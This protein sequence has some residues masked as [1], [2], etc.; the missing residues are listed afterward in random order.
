LNRSQA[1][2][3]MTDRVT[4]RSPDAELVKQFLGNLSSSG[5]KGEIGLHVADRLVNAT[6]NSVY[7][8]MPAAV[9][10][11]RVADDL[12]LI[13]SL[14]SQGV[15][16]IPLAAR[17][18]GTG[19]NGQALSAGVVV[20]TSRHLNR[21]LKFD[22]ERLRVVVE[23]GVVLGQLNA[24]LGTHGLFFPPTV[25]T[26]NRATLGGMIATDASGKGSRLY[27]KTSDYIE[28]M[29]VVLA[30]GSNF[31]VVPTPVSQIEDL[32][33]QES[34]AARGQL[35]VLRTATTF[36][37]EIDD[38]F[39]DMNR[40]LTGYN[41]KM[42]LDPQKGLMLHR[43]LAGSE[44][45]L[46]ITKFVELRVCRKPRQRVLLV[47]R[48][49]SFDGAL[50]DVG[51]L[52]GADPAAI[53]TIDDK[54]LALAQQDT[55]WA[56]LEG[57]LGHKVARDVK[58]INFV[59]LA[60]DDPADIDAR[61][62]TLQE[63]M[64][65]SGSEA[66][67]DYTLVRDAKLIDS[68]WGLREKSVGLL[69]KLPGKRQGAAFVE[70]TA[71]PP[72]RLPEY[73][74]EFR[75]ILDRHGLVYGMF[76]HADVGCLHVRPAL[77]MTNR[78]DAALLRPISDEV[79]ALAKRYGGLLWGEHGRG[80]RGEYSPFFFGPVLYAELCKIKAAFDPQNIF[81]PGKLAS[82]PG[83]PAVI[84]IDEPPLRGE[85]DRQIAA[86]VRTGYAAALSCNGNGVCFSWDAQDPMCPSYKATRDRSQ[87]PKGRATLLREWMRRK[88]LVA[89]SFSS[90]SLYEVEEAVHDSL[91]SCL[92]CKA[93]ANQCPI[94]VDIPAMKARFLNDYYR[95]RR[96]PLR[97]HL[98][99]EMERL[100]PL[101]R[102]WPRAAN[103]LMRSRAIRALISAVGLVD[104]PAIDP[105]GLKKSAFDL[106]ALALLSIKEKHRSVILVPDS[107]TDV[108][109]GVVPAA[110]HSLLT[111]LGFR[112]HVAPLYP[113][114][115][116]LHVLGFL[117][118]FR[119]VAEMARKRHK[120]ML[121]TGVPVLGIEPVATLMDRIE[122][123]EALPCRG[124]AV[125][126]TIDEF[127]AQEI[128]E[129]RISLPDSRENSI[130]H[131]FLHCTERTAMPAVETRWR[132][133]FKAFGLQLFIE[134]T[135][136][137][138]MAGL[139][140]H[141][142]EHAEMSK[143]LFAMSWAEP[144]QKL[145][146][147]QLL[148]TGFSCRSQAKRL[149]GRQLRHPVQALLEALGD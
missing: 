68:L 45:T 8:V 62:V 28:S 144:I 128:D 1:R 11:P 67:L 138:G 117:E 132:N 21:I 5:Y 40:G 78:H 25:S 31:R 137:C 66:R 111:K 94:Q 131:L 2:T 52:L 116:P 121:D 9:L 44:G 107:F 120:Q 89:T 85:F 92:S 34:L 58:A 139:F 65:Q 136:C 26:A 80:F 109:D 69:G 99:G 53:E 64:E 143:N 127:L 112:V 47:I 122:Y 10:Y 105:S 61:V 55:M 60:S 91:S 63:L 36:R 75:A 114:G 82:L 19:T 48:Y 103:A 140:G 23:P 4:S 123:Q 6:D 97:H 135:G 51:P 104:L 37:E 141:E 56:G 33:G 142:R 30:D 147:K 145:S 72:G 133:I 118:R 102:A 16:P 149:T 38:V 39:P 43:I 46:A 7:Q 95:A 93:C 17:G 130:F 81:N 71:V 98:I 87:S 90:S 119:G 96:R 77:D 15:K 115:K 54:I 74:K 83:G 57:I 100:L 88:S 22:V 13:V 108:Y 32:E 125:V 18:G 76:G 70:D 3:I 14:A 50:N 146:D 35:Q 12:N 101:A 113:N 20:D 86:D 41:L 29:D 79:A 84:L 24:F 49:D 73:V 134:R 129:G 27:G 106:D 110:A 126:K 124:G 59:E 148:V 42:A